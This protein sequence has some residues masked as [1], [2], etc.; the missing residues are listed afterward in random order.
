MALF[1]KIY[2]QRTN[3]G[4]FIKEFLQ[5]ENKLLWELNHE[6]N[7]HTIVKRFKHFPSESINMNNC[8]QKYTKNYQAPGQGPTQGQIQG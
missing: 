7:V 2:A 4:V 6:C 3:Y 8:T 1:K 5:I